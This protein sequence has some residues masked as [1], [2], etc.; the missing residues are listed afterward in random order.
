MCSKAGI[1]NTKVV[2]EE[3]PNLGKYGPQQRALEWE[4]YVV[5]DRKKKKPTG[6]L[7]HP[8]LPRCGFRVVDLHG[9]I[10][11]LSGYVGKSASE[12]HIKKSTV[13][14]KLWRKK[15]I[16]RKENGGKKRIKKDTQTT[17][18]LNRLIYMYEM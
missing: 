15:N 7:I 11:P 6:G 17:Q 1:T 9:Q 3:K 5:Q 18:A 13:G 12:V 14:T 4:L 2:K 10:S 16:C 8:V